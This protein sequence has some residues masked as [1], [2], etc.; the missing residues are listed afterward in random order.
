MIKKIYGLIYILIVLLSP[1]LLIKDNFV[2]NLFILKYLEKKPSKAPL[3][4]L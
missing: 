2:K 1:E 4:L 3:I